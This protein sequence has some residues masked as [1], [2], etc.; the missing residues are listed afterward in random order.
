MAA[1]G[2]E[3]K[4]FAVQKIKE[5]FG[6]NFV[7][8][9]DKKLYIECP[10]AGG[11]VQVAIS[12]TCPKIPVAFASSSAAIPTTKDGGMDFENMTVI[13]SSTVELTQDEQDNIK[14]LLAM[15]E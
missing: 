8:E 9:Y 15:V 11:M 12:L 5:A 7:G 6:A 10:E 14:R 2:T 4:A 3:A 13:Q 1:K